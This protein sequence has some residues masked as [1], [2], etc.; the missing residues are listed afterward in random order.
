MSEVQFMLG[1]GRAI[2]SPPS[3]PASVST[4][5]KGQTGLRGTP[6]L[7]PPGPLYSS[8]LSITPVVFL[9]IRAADLGVLAQE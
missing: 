9:G 4:A 3:L 6:S 8:A 7:A 2:K 5:Q 1:T